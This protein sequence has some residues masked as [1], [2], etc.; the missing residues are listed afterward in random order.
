MGKR[1][2]VGFFQTRLEIIAEVLLK[3][4]WGQDLNIWQPVAQPAK[5]RMFIP[6]RCG[7]CKTTVWV[8]LRDMLCGEKRATGP[9]REQKPAGWPQCAYQSECLM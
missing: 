8:L 9:P 3:R 5:Q 7:E 2:F 1:F 6:N 4:S